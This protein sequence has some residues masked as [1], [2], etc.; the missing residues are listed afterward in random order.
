MF[1]KKKTLAVMLIILLLISVAGYFGYG[2]YKEPSRLSNIPLIKN[3]VPAAEEDS[4]TPELSEEEQ[5]QQ[6]VAG[7]K[8]ALEEKEVEKEAYEQ[9]ITQLRQQLANNEVEELQNE[10]ARLELVI[11]DLQNQRSNQDAAYQDLAQY[12]ALMKA[13]DAAGIL[14][15]LSDDDAIG[16]ISR[17]ENDA[18]ASV[19]QNM[20]QD[21]AATITK[22]M[23]TVSM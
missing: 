13:K 18:A 6:E 11:S 1:K 8:A 15:K 10:V 14:S 17:M 19:M 5:V 21:R 3:F 23:L 4:E 12:Y 7:L 20:D 2:F 22:K 16:I 9:E